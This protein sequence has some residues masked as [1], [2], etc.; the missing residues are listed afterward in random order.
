LTPFVHNERLTQLLL[1]LPVGLVAAAATAFTAS[2]EPLIV[3]VLAG[4]AALA[5]VGLTRPW[6]VLYLAILCAPLEVFT[7]QVGG[8][9]GLSVTE[10]LL[11]ASGLAWFA[12]QI[13]TRQ[14]LGAGS[15]LTLPLVLLVATILPGFLVAENPF[16]TLKQ[17]VSWSLL[18]LVFQMI[19]TEG[20]M[21]RLR[22]LLV[23][24]AL[25]AGGVAILAI[26]KTGGEPEQVVNFGQ[27]ATGRATGP[28]AHPN[29]L[30]LFLAMAIPIQI[31]V[32]LRGPPLLRPF[33]LGAF[34]VGFVACALSLSRSAFLAVV[35]ALAVMLFWRPSRIAAL[36]VAV[37]LFAASFIGVNPIGRVLG[38]ENLVQRIESTQIAGT[39]DPRRL[40]YERTPEMIIDH[41]LFG[42]GTLNYQLAAPRYEIVDIAG[43]GTIPSHAH[44]ILL[45]TAAE[46]GLLALGV[47]IWFA[48]ALAMMLAR[49][50][51]RARGEIRAYAFGI[52]GAFVALASE[53]L[54]DYVLA[55]NV[56]AGLGFAFAACAVILDRLARQQQE[57]GESRE[58]APAA[59]AAAAA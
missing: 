3:P 41:P 37:A 25:A 38:G 12:R 30:G 17:M 6:A 31:A 48:V 34:A 57:A 40:V 59:A 26:L 15:A 19:V 24:F 22:N 8:S 27:T 35:A 56:I 7:F 49:T 13:V 16:Y 2:K 45:N 23:A 58:R 5:A 53:S 47:L 9:F 46:R 42:V 51:R 55:S 52:T 39:D 44:N 28:F 10:G 21:D 36:G 20:D 33:A 50:C 54:L 11:F 18:L 32:A 43:G 1:A 14:P 29:A 4:I